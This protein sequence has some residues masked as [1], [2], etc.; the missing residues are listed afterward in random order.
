MLYSH[1][2]S[3]GKPLPFNPTFHHL[4]LCT[5]FIWLSCC[6]KLLLPSR[7]VHAQRDVSIKRLYTV[8][9]TSVAQ[10]LP[11]VGTKD[12]SYYQLETPA[13]DGQ[14]VT[15]GLV[16]IMRA[17]AVIGFRQRP[18]RFF[19]SA[20]IQDFRDGIISLTA[21]CT[22]IFYEGLCRC[23]KRSTYSDTAAWVQ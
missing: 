14:L 15:G 19:V 3:A 13:D 8:R 20:R 17:F 22:N 1:F 18:S 16:E 21:L 12:R 11:G 2:H 10:Y 7:T 5:R 4:W 9:W 23:M 6:A